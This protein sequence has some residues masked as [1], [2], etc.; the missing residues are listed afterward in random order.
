MVANI[1]VIPTRSKSKKTRK[2]YNIFHSVIDTLVLF[3]FIY[4]IQILNTPS[5]FS[6]RKMALFYI[7]VK[8]IFD[9]Y[10]KKTIVIPKI[11]KKTSSRIVLVVAY[12]IFHLLFLILVNGFDENG[13]Y[14]IN[15]VI[16]FLIY[17]PVGSIL[18]TLYFSDSFRFM[19]ALINSILI[20]S[21]IIFGQ[22][23]LS[24]F[25]IF[26]DKYFVS[27]G[28]VSYLRENRA[29]GLGAEGA[30]LSL[31]LFCGMFLIGYLFQKYKRGDVTLGLSYFYILHPGL[32]I[33]HF[34]IRRCLV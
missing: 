14:V 21:T 5:I 18:F 9:L 2:I 6:T 29:N 25:R 8:V 11:I 17:V 22:F 23:L 1:G 3:F 31:T 20:Q 27:T 7:G 4:E 16:Y 12:T 34:L 24:D 28:N 26:L 30:A 19:K 33:D 10:T 15:R 32:C 13:S